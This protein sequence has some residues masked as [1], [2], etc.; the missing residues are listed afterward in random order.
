MGQNTVLRHGDESVRNIRKLLCLKLMS[1]FIGWYQLKSFRILFNIL[2]FG[3]F[4][5]ELRIATVSFVMSVRLHGIR[6]TPTGR[7]FVKFRISD[8]D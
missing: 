1:V 8:F 7:I 5:K 2:C 3:A 4:V 6:A